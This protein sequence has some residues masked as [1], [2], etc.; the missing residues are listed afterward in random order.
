MKKNILLILI[1]S[2][3]V[4]VSCNNDIEKTQEISI[5]DNYD[6]LV[7]TPKKQYLCIFKTFSNNKDIETFL[8][9]NPIDNDFNNHDIPVSTAEIVSFYSNYINYWE[10]EIENSL[11]ILQNNLEN[12][13]YQKLKDSQNNWTEYLKDNNSIFSEIHIKTAGIGSEIPVLSSFKT[14]SKI[15][16]RSLELIEYCILLEGQYEF[17]F[18]S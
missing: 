5:I 18:V 16:D 4:L 1:I 12:E 17:V 8:N 3:F 2:L 9:N 7:E 14:L 15:R 11:T 6:N 13:N 10:A